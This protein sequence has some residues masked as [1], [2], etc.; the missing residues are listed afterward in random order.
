[1]EF[2]RQIVEGSELT[3]VIPLP[4]SLRSGKVEV[5]VLPIMEKASPS[6]YS[7]QNIDEMLV[8]SIT[9]SLI[10]AIPISEISLEEIRE[11]RLKK[12]ESVD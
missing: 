11:E 8:G 5:I 10:G 3:N 12:Y 6:K 2:V 7:G 4:T 1:M 9:Q